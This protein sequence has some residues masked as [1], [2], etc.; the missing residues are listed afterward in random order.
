MV[1]A[2]VGLVWLAVS[3]HLFVNSPSAAR[4]L[5]L[6]A[7]EA[8][9][10]TLS[11]GG[12]RV[13]WSLDDAQLG[14]RAAVR[15]L[16]VTDPDGQEVMAAR[17]VRARLSLW[18]LVAGLRNDNVRLSIPE[19][20][21]DRPLLRLRND[22]RGRLTLNL[23]FADPDAPPP[24]PPKPFALTIGKADLREG[25]FDMDLPGTALF[26]SGLWLQSP[27]IVVQ[28][29]PGEPVDVRYQVRDAVAARVAMR[30]G[31]MQL[32]PPIPDAS[33]QIA[34][35]VGDAQSVRL[36]AVSA[37]M[38]PLQLR[39]GLKHMPA[40][41]LG[42]AD[43]ASAW[44]VRTTTTGEQLLVR[45]GSDDPHVRELLGRG[46]A[47]HAAMSAS[48]RADPDTGFVLE[49]DVQAGGLVAGFWAPRIAGHLRVETGTPG[50]APVRVIS[51]GVQA[52]AYG[53]TLRSPRIDYW[54]PAG[55]NEHWVRGTLSVDGMRADAPLL[56][57]G[58]GLP[59]GDLTPILAAGALAGELGVVSRTRLHPD[60]PVDYDVAIDA[61]LELRRDD[62]LAMLRQRLPS[63]RMVGGLHTNF[64]GERGLRVGMRDL[65]LSADDDDGNRL[66]RMRGDGVLDVAGKQT[67]LALHL[68]VP[69]LQAWLAPFGVTQV[70]GA[71]RL[72]AGELEGDWRDPA[73]I[74]HLALDN[75]VLPGLNARHLRSRVR[76]RQGV[77]HFDD[78]AVE[79]NFGTGRADVEIGLFGR[80][81]GVLRSSW[82][83]R[84]RNASVQHVDLA[85]LVPGVTGTGEVRNGQF[86]LDARD[87]ARTLAGSAALTLRDVRMAGEVLDRVQG[88]VQFGGGDCSLANGRVQLHGA[89][90]QDDLEVSGH[91][92]L[93]AQTFSTEFKVPL[94]PFSRLRSL[95][96][97]P[98]HG[99]VGVSG[100][101]FGSLR[102]FEGE[103]AVQLRGLGWDKIRLGDGDF[104]L[105]K[106]RGGPAVWTAVDDLDYFD[107]QPG[108]ELTF[109]GLGQL[110][111][112]ALNVRTHG[113]LDP[114]AVAGLPKPHGLAARVEGE[115]RTLVDLRP[116]ATRYVV[117]T[118]LGAGHL[119]VEF[120]GGHRL[121]NTSTA[122]VRLTPERIA[123][124]D[125]HFA[126]HRSEFEVCGDLTLP[127]EGESM[128]MAL[129]VAGSVDVP[130]SGAWAESLSDLD[131]RLDILPDPIVAADPASNCLAAAQ[132][133]RGRLR[134]AGPV[135]APRIQG[136][137]QTRAGKVALR[138]YP[139]EIAI[140]EGGRLQI[141]SVG[142]GGLSALHLHIP[143]S[144]KLAMRIDNGTL[145][146]DGRVGLK[147]LQ[148]DT[149][150]L[151]F[152]GD[153]L[154]VDVPKQYA[155]RVSPAVH[156]TA[157]HYGDPE[158]R[159]WWARGRVVVSE[160]I[161]YRNFDTLSGVVGNAGGGR[162]VD[163]YS[164]PLT[165]SWPEL[166]DLQLD[167]G[168]LGGNFEVSSRF[169]L[170]KADLVTEFGVQVKGTLPALRVY[171]HAKVV[172]G[173]GSQLSYAFNNL[174]FDVDRGDLDFT[175][176]WMR[177]YLDL[178]LRTDI[179]VR[180]SNRS[181]GLTGA[182]GAELSTDSASAD[183]VVQ[184]YVQIAG[185]WS[186]HSKDF[187]IRLSSNK[188]DTEKDVQ[189]LILFRR[190]C[191]DAGGSAPR[192][193]TDMLFGE[194]INSLATSLLKT[195]VDTI[196]IDFDPANVGVT[197]EASKKFGKSMAL[198]ARVQTGRET[199]YTANFAFK[200]T[201]RLSLNG[202]FRRERPVDASGTQE[203]PV[204]VYESKL[205]YKV[206]LDD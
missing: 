139:H 138:K 51:T 30:V 34:R 187:K 148:I 49:G 62:L 125:T 156:L 71:L 103:V 77:V 165:E 112:L 134:L 12:L 108:S 201:D 123:I 52:D 48:F 38:P 74:G 142:S 197:A 8:L 25:R 100:R 114:F 88:D 79:A 175:G 13:G 117:D 199:R 150:D 166:A 182:F 86:A 90:P 50:A 37:Q 119:Q 129:F 131:L 188:G 14:L 152:A 9:P 4:Q 128:A 22:P 66:I 149:M 57:E 97:M 170:G 40:T 198:G 159:D 99:R 162:T 92:D 5:S 110:T 137:L 39:D 154:P 45:T 11:I 177:P 180:V 196:A 70:S 61:E 191:G 144:H 16:R 132:G 75:L 55:L 56:A 155:M 178:S 65:R 118:A 17:T 42:H 21:L 167:L 10:G 76:M 15:D 151:M 163:T 113:E 89:V 93:V 140:D 130:R 6:L 171:D 115:V 80:D 44:G 73:V 58:V 83:T 192:L 91:Y 82:P 172:P 183:E 33:M 102:D 157:R 204:T 46:Y 95:D 184:V 147:N 105:T 136:T 109:A 54:M 186:E 164:K 160:G 124:G 78:L 36:T 26:A 161:Y 146:I 94:L 195:F 111:T 205:R 20:L 174:V 19:L 126:L 27:G 190:R 96:G 104:A 120:A 173:S 101:L 24:G 60:Q 153:E 200:I 3:A 63:V 158:R 43:I 181:G 193:T 202:L 116:G 145:K 64:D 194:A 84:V 47:A 87:W 141:A 7:S 53:G 18:P 121:R 179:A 106:R 203:A 185:V 85:R 189:C 59:P 67:R 206:P 98:L 35:I 2:T 169:T 135:D 32:L 176:D 127:R 143:Q 69:R 1:Q 72:D 41:V 122:L 107:V 23:A 81:I 28:T 29:R 133:G 68:D 31:S 168:V